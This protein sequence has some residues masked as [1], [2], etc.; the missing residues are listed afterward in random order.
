MDFIKEAI[1]QINTEEN[2]LYDF[3]YNLVF[4]ISLK[5]SEEDIQNGRI[6]TIEDSKERL[7]QKYE[8]LDI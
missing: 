1:N 7:M 8:H 6:M 5:E 2:I 4:Y 3:I